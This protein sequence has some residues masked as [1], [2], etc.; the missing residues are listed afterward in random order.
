MENRFED[1]YSQETLQRIAKLDLL[2]ATWFDCFAEKFEKSSDV[3]DLVSLWNIESIEISDLANNSE[4][5]SYSLAWRIMWFRSHWR[6]SF[7]T[8]K[9]ESW[10]IQ[11][12]FNRWNLDINNWFNPSTEISLDWEII[13]GYSF[14]KKFIDIGDIVWVKWNL[15]CTKTGQ[16][17]LFVRELQLL[18][19]TLN[20]L[21]EKFHGLKDQ[22]T[23][24][25][26]RYLDILLNWWVKEMLQRRSKY[27]KAIRD[28]MDWEWFTEVDTPTLEVTTWWA[29]AR[30]FVTHHN[31]LDMEVFLRISAW[32][33]WQKRLMVAWF[34]KIYELWR[35]FRNEWISHEHAQDYMQME[36]YWAYA[37]YQ[38]MMWLVKNMYLYIVD[39]VYSTRK[40]NIRWFEIDFDQEWEIIDYTQI[41]KDKLWIDI[42]NS[43]EEE[44][45]SKLNELWANY[46]AWNRARLVDYL[47]KYLRKSIKGPAFL[48]N[49]PKFTSPLAKSDIHNPEITHRF[50]VIIAWSEVWNGYSELNDP[51]D[52]KERFEAQQA[53]RDWWDDEAQMADWDFVEALM[54]GMPPTAGFGVSERLFAF[55]EW[56][57]IRETQTFPLVKSNN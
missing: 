37:D 8:L 4:A 38:K 10:E 47:W 2:R 56:M 42:F 52:Q 32:E 35:I 26:K 28:F 39:K 6:L 50:H 25:R 11:L 20:P 16:L 23:R 22:N 18:T 54:H 14:L 44:M 12:V 51:I 57:S 29:D 27:F 40:F 49:E 3:S 53:L 9:D 30:P 55:L 41:I 48:I 17:S 24:F 36:V 5:I 34:E 46:E 33:L 21:P 7:A 1:W 31:A 15:F 45:I 19:K 43:T 13:D